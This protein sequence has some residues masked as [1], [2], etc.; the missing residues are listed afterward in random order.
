M[1]VAALVLLHTLEMV[2]TLAV[3][4][5]DGTLRHKR[6]RVDIVDELEY[7]ARLALLGKN[8][9]HVDFVSGIA[10]ATVDDRTSA[11]CLLV[12]ES[13]QF[14]ISLRDNKETARCG[15]SG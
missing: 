12:D 13:A 14:L 7:A 9:K 10:A 4:A 11:L 5:Y 6:L 1:Q 15:A 2:E 8:E 3:D